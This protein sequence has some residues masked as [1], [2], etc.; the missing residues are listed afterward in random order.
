MRRAW[1]LGLAIAIAFLGYAGSAVVGG[2]HQ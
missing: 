2:L 1:P